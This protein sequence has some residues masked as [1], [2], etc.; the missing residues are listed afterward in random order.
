MLQPIKKSW[1]IIDFKHIEL[2]KD[3]KRQKAVK[4]I[5][6]YFG[7]ASDATS[8]AFSTNFRIPFCPKTSFDL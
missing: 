4:T 8:F 3:L 1:G 7:N 2:H 5:A 6:K